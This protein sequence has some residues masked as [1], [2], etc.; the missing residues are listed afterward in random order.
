MHSIE[1]VQEMG[2]G[3]VRLACANIYFF[4]VVVV[5]VVTTV[6][7]VVPVF[8]LVADDVVDLR[9]VLLFVALLNRRLTTFVTQ[10]LMIK[11]MIRFVYFVIAL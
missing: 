9:F 8:F 10:R 7:V 11:L 5:V 2:S 6:L 4:R 3:A 1:S